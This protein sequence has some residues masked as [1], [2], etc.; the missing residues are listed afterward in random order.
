MLTEIAKEAI[1]LQNCMCELGFEK[2]ADT[3][4]FND[5][6][7]ALKL[8]ENPIF[9]ARSKH[10]DIRF[11]FFHFFRQALEKNYS[12]TFHISSEDM[13]FDILTKALPRRKHEKCV[14]M[15]GL[16]SVNGVCQQRIE[17]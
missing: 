7:S 14:R 6:M 13:I 9:H 17:G 2:M 15:M 10:I 1:Y 8:A 11:N 4:I 5:N 12:E 3:H 16:Q